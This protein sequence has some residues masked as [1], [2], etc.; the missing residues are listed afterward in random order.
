[1]SQSK[2]NAKI[3]NLWPKLLVITV[4]LS[5]YGVAVTWLQSDF[6]SLVIS[7]GGGL[8][9]IPL[10]FIFYEIWQEKSHRKL[11]ESVYDFAENK[12]RVSIK[13]VK[14]KLELLTEGA[15]VYFEEGTVLIDDED[16][17]NIKIQRLR[18]EGYRDD[19][20]SD[21]LLNFER[22]NIFETLANGRYLAFQLNNLSVSEEL[23][24][25]EE[26][27]ANAF[28]MKRLDG[29]Q[30]RTIIFLIEALKMLEAFLTLHHDV[31][32]PSSINFHGFRVEKTHEG[33]CSLIFEDLSTGESEVLDIIP[34]YDITLG[35][36]PLPAYV[37]N[38]DY[39]VILSDLIYDIVDGINQWKSVSNSVYMDF[40]DGKIGV[41]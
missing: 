15:S 18:D 22:E 31:F 7:I 39:Y 21:D 1:M 33:L 4:G 26:L 37:V 41:L 34:A 36:T 29:G 12:M 13:A 24:R 17:E 40:E 6:K 27:L 5:L 28:I 38:P 16:I 30:V 14:S 23:H 35:G 9:S 32:V 20:Y 8:V 11:N 10:V 19:P 2:L 3:H 25:L